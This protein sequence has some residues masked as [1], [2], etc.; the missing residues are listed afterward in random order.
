MSNRR[1]DGVKNGLH[2]SLHTSIVKEA[3]EDTKTKSVVVHIRLTAHQ[4]NTL[5]AVLS[6]EGVTMQEYFAA[7]A[8]EKI[9]TLPTRA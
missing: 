6:L 9:A 8:V 5:K 2:A 7:K 1:A 3:V 4:R